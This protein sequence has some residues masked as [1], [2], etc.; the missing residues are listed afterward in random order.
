MKK[1]FLLLTLF[2]SCQFSFAQTVNDK[3]REAVELMDS[4]D[5]GESIILLNEAI[6]MEPENYVARYELVYAYYL[7]KDYKEVLNRLKKLKKHEDAN[8]LCYA[9]LG[10]VYDETG[11]VK[12]ALQAYDEG[13]KK[14]PY[15]GSLYLNKGVAYLRQKEYK[16]ALHSFEK[17][18][19]VAPSYSSNYYWAAIIFCLHAEEKLWGMIY[20]E[21]FMNLE[22]NSPR[23]ERISFLLYDTYRNGITIENNT[24]VSVAFYKKDI[25]I[26]LDESKMEDTDYM[27]KALRLPYA[28]EVYE[29]ALLLALTPV[30]EE[31]NLASLDIA[32]SNFARIYE[33]MWK[34]KYPNVLFDYQKQIYDLG[35]MSAYNYW[36]LMQGDVDSFIGWR[37]ENEEL[38][39]RFVNWFTRSPISVNDENKF[40][41]INYDN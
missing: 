13:L 21:I 19:E 37:L 35:L 15:S 40:L 41:R 3:I 31:I 22:R 8:D 14:F 12:K 9:M 23:T 16:E 28:A 7:R 17:G 39:D 20:G 30:P 38:W 2:I 33:E 5:I 11:E 25:A 10:N 32:R 18:I 34:E 24:A 6:K 26:H 27:M 4:G 1:I 36:V 29:P